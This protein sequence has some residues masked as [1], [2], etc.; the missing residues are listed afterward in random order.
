MEKKCICILTCL[1][2]KEK[3]GYAM[4]SLILNHHRYLNLSQ[5]LQICN[6]SL[7]IPRH[8]YKK[9]SYNIVFNRFLTSDR[10]FCL[11]NVLL[12]N[13]CKIYLIMSATAFWVRSHWDGFGKWNN[14]AHVWN[15]QEWLSSDARWDTPSK[16]RCLL[17]LLFQKTIS[18][19]D[20][21]SEDSFLQASVFPS[22]IF[23]KI[24]EPQLPSSFSH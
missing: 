14:S 17:P 12:V 16:L 9:P 3:S 2:K 11:S 4:L 19:Y 22:V 8:Y 5:T 18:Q 20:S 10:C 24:D 1:V 15:Y 13:A 7:I 6:T 23:Y 21:L